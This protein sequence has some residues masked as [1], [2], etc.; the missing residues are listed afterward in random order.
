[1]A[2]EPP[3]TSALWQKPGRYWEL[4]PEVPYTSYAEYK[5]LTAEVVV[6]YSSLIRTSM[7]T[8][9]QEIKQNLVNH[10]FDLAYIGLSWELRQ[11][12]VDKGPQIIL[13]LTK[14]TGRDWCELVNSFLVC[15]LDSATRAYVQG[16]AEFPV[17]GFDAAMADV[18]TYLQQQAR[19]FIKDRN[20][21]PMGYYSFF[22]VNFK[23]YKSSLELDYEES[24]N[25]PMA[26]FKQIMLAFVMGGHDRLGEGSCVAMLD[27]ELMRLIFKFEIFDG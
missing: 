10:V 22:Y 12:W 20:L 11:K 16:K 13:K 23:Y 27:D 8:E 9:L 26:K 17:D 4:I 24:Q 15:A 1:M 18:C 14:G 7:Y 25:I 21:N 3:N 6:E 2:F 5:S 19:I